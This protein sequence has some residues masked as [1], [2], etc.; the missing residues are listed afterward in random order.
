MSDR[1]P[2]FKYNLGDGDVIIVRGSTRAVKCNLDGSFREYS[3]FNAGSGFKG[4]DSARYFGKAEVD[5]S[6]IDSL[7]DKSFEV[8]SRAATELIGAPFSR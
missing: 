3:V 4:S 6:L 8:V 7:S 1:V 5:D 2:I